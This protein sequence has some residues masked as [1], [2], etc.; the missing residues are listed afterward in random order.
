MLRWRLATSGASAAPQPR[1]AHASSSSAGARRA[2]RARLGS[3][4]RPRAPSVPDGQ[5]LGRGVGLWAQCEAAGGVHAACW[6]EPA[7][8]G[9]P[10]RAARVGITRPDTV[11]FD[12]RPDGWGGDM[13][14]CHM[15]IV[16]LSHVHSH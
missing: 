16:P 9:A 6:G 7:A 12:L 3:G 2:R 1:T 15:A 8:S 4:R 11:T 5:P 13:S 14:I 10:P